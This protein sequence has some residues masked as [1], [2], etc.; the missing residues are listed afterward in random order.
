MEK[1][2]CEKL[3]REGKRIV[4]PLEYNGGF[5]EFFINYNSLNPKLC[6]HH[7]GGYPEPRLIEEES[8]LLTSAFLYKM[9]DNI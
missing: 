6:A 1:K 3:V 5:W 8:K 2:E 9:K 4:T 7:T